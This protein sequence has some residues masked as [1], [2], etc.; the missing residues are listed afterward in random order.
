MTYRR[1]LPAVGIVQTMKTI[2]PPNRTITSRASCTNPRGSVIKPMIKV[3]PNKGCRTIPYVDPVKPKRL[4]RSQL[5]RLLACCRPGC[6]SSFVLPHVRIFIRPSDF[7]ELTSSQN[8]KT[9]RR[10]LFLVSLSSVLRLSS[11]CLP[12]NGKKARNSV[13][14][15]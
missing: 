2:D 6:D 10:I 4:P 13:H 8:L 5:I 7:N 12:I 3:P 11:F 14:I 9:T 1:L 15:M